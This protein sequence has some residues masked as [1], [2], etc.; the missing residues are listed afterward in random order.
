MTTRTKNALAFGGLAIVLIAALVLVTRHRKVADTRSRALSAVPAGAL[1]VASIDLDALRASPV[2]APFLREGRQ[3]P[4]LGSVREVCGKDPMD[5]LREA[6]IAF[7]AA[8]D[9]GDFGLAAAG[10]VDPDLVSSCAAKVIEARG[11]KPVIG[12]IG[13]FTT[14]RDAALP[15]GGGEIAVRKGGLL[16]LGGGPYLRA[17]IDAAEGRL[18]TVRSSNAHQRL[19]NEVGASP[20]LLTFML[21]TEQRATIA[22][23]MGDEGAS[24]GASIVGGALGATFGPTVVVRG[25]I[26]CDREEPC[27]RVAERLRAMRDARAK[28][29][30]T[31]LVGFGAAL[32]GLQIEAK[33]EL[34]RLTLKLPEGEAATLVER[35]MTLRGMRHP[36]PSEGPPV[37]KASASA[38]PPDDVIKVDAGPKEKG[39]AGPS[40]AGSKDDRDAG[41]KGDRDAGRR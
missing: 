29:F 19:A 15:A 17:M 6:A 37:P 41:S 1:L 8:G 34:I 33:G 11:G 27:A 25:V 21:T 4:G 3:I 23:V 2:G 31:R 35:L 24:P 9:T 16:L 30:A 14:V 28:D 38:P 36:M 10:E 32:E 40:D 12:T 5:T 13:T 26:A 18:P 39:D 7:P 22:E 20:A